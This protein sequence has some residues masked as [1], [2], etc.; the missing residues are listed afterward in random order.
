M[1]RDSP[2]RKMSDLQG[3]LVVLWHCQRKKDL[4][5]STIKSMCVDEIILLDKTLSISAAGGYL[6]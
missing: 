3:A 1:H 6:N 5:V 4:A 2:F